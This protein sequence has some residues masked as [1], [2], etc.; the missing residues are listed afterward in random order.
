MGQDSVG[1]ILLVY[2]R[3]LYFVGFMWWL[4]V[5]RGLHSCVLRVWM[6][7]VVFVLIGACG[8]VVSVSK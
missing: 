5:L 3:G 2:Y 4:R 8:C 7:S 6:A 1:C